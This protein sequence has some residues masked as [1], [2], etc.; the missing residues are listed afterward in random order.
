MSNEQPAYT[1]GFNWLPTGSKW[2]GTGWLFFDDEYAAKQC[3][4]QLQSMRIGAVFV[5]P[6]HDA[7]WP[8]VGAAHSY[9]IPHPNAPLS[10]SSAE[11][12]GS[13]D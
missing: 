4:K 1:V 11:A 3:R 6:F 7:D 8:H 12:A 10:R 5:R 13:E 9:L 2:V